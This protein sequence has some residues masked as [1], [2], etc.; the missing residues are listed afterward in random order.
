M[1]RILLPI[2][3][4]ACA[5]HFASA[6]ATTFTVIN[7][8]DA[9]NGSLR[10]AIL[11]A[12][13]AGGANTIAFA[14]TGAGPHTITLA[15]QLP[16]IGGTLTIDGY[17]QPGSAPNTQAPDQ[18]GLDAILKIEINGG[19]AGIGFFLAGGAAF[20][21]LTVQG[22][23]LNHFT[24][25]AIVG[26]GGGAGTSQLNV[27]GNYIGTTLDG[28]ALPSPG[29][30]GSAIRS[31]FSSAQIG[32][33]QAWQRNLLSGNG[34][35][36]V[37]A[38]GPTIIE[39]NLIGTDASGTSAIP[40][41]FA[42]N[43]GGIILGSRMNV[44]IG[45][46]SVA[47]RNIISGNHSWGIGIWSAFGASGTPSGFAIKGNY[48]G[49]DVSGTMP[50][51]N[52]YAELQFAQYG[53]GIQVQNSGSDPTPLIIGGFATGEQNLI[54]YNTGAGILASSNSVGEAFDSRANEIHHNRG[55]G[56]VNLDIG[57]VGPTPN[58]VDDADGG[59]NGQQNWPEILS[60]S[61][62]GNQLA[63]TYRVDS[64][65]VNASYPLRIDFHADAG[66]GS[67]QWLTQ[68]SYPAA[69]AQL[70][71]TI[72]LLVPAGVRAIPFVA[73]A[74]DA[75]GHTSELSPA[76]DVIFEDGFE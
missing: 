43:W 69:S 35:A 66:G 47:S 7:N 51:P 26:N 45:G 50:V 42:S 33:T 54:A 31:G 62:A 15:S 64:T 13:S 49:T 76:F 17:T 59:A 16:A 71:R 37:L 57:A 75:G 1:K 21:T 53:G 6:D 24:G 46:A 55:V 12:N 19:T 63:L 2:L 27:Y 72:T 40:N 52:G 3:A 14:I 44:R 29:N 41:G 58:D 67:G 23:A 38:N 61:Q 20:I 65:T 8:A 22:L 68:D 48:I 34:G 5:L 32:G 56:R 9:G 10:Q 36:G 74:T 25:D 73:T 60:A 39:G 70:S 30:N 4:A 18:G 11:D 28:T